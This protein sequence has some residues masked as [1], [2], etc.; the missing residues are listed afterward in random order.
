VTGDG[1][2]RT[3]RRPLR[4]SQSGDRRFRI[5][6]AGGGG[7]FLPEVLDETVRLAD[8]RN[9]K[10]AVLQL[11][12]VWGTGLGLAHPGLR[13]NRQEQQAAID[14]LDRALEHLAAHDVPIAEQL[15]IGTRNPAKTILRHIDRTGTGLVVMGAP[16]K[17][18]M[19]DW[20]W[21]NEPYRVARKADVEVVLV[22]PQVKV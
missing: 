2:R 7:P 17:R 14:T 6:L 13:P 3:P 16:A 11:L 12:R 15:I 4:A 9:A 22:T 5:L 19:G 1:D 18:R 21:G 10:V 8:E 20:N